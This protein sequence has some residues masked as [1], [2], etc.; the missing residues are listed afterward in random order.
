MRDTVF[1]AYVVIDFS[2]SMI[3]PISSTEDRTRMDVA[4]DIIPTLLKSM[5]IDASTAESLRVRVIGFNQYVTFCTDLFDY[6]G[7]KNWYE[8]EK[9]TFISQCKYQTRYGEVFDKLR[10]CINL[11]L[12]NIISEG[13]TYYRPLVYFL[14]D[15]K[16]EGE[17]SNDRD[18][19]YKALTN[20]SQEAW[21]PLIVFVGIGPEYMTILK[22]YGASRYGNKHGEYMTNNEAMTFIIKK[23]KKTGD[24]LAF[25]NEQVV[26]T[27][28]NSLQ[29]RLRGNNSKANNANEIDFD[30]FDEDVEKR[31]KDYFEE[32]PRM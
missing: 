23:G 31:L 10:S 25:L 27:I 12:G 24:G 9:N 13:K 20:N 30:S 28:R 18:I 19:K 15:G 11:D 6:Y 16:P 14:T 26:Q 5:K 32:R 21:N 3:R 2:E 22:Q 29:K 4:I 8:K 1:T 7:L 17:E